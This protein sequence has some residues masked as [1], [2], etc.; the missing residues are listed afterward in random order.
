MP[1][2]SGARVDKNNVETA[3]TIGAFAGA[4]IGLITGLAASD[5]GFWTGVCIVA[6]MTVGIWDAAVHRF[7][8]PETE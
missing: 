7:R 3:L 6:G 2:E 4:S 5:V 1:A 8:P